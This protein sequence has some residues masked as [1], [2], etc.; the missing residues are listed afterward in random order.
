MTATTFG[1][2]S[3]V[4]VPVRR[5]EDPT[6]LRG[7]ATY[8][9]NLA[10]PGALHLAFVRSSYA[11]A[12]L[13]GVDT[14]D[15]R[16]MPGVVAVYTAGDL[17]FPDHT[18]MMQLNPNVV[19]PALARD[20]VRFVGD[21]IAV[22]VAETKAQAVD[23]A[24]TVV[25]EYEP[26]AAVTDM[27]DALAPDAPVQFDALG[28]NVIMGAR[29]PDGYDPLA[30]AEVVVRGRFENQRVAV[31]P[32]EGS[33]VAVVPGDDGDGHELT[34]YL[35]C[36]MPH[37]NRNALATNFGVE[38]EKVRLI[39]PHVGGSFGA[40][41]WAPEDIVAVRVARE[42][43]R[44]VKWVET[45]SENMIAMPHGRGQ[46][47]YLELGLLR[48]GT[49]VGLRCRI[50]GD[51]GAYGGFGGMLAFG[52]TRMMSQGVYRIPKI[53]YDCAVALTNLAPMGAYRG[54][55]RPEAAAMLERILDMAADELDIDPVD[56]RRRNFLQPD[57]FPYS[58]VTGVT[59]DIGDYDA[60]LT[61]A[62]RI[63]GYDELRAEQATRRERGDV[64]LLGIGV[65]AY[66]EIT[67]GGSSSEYAEV[68]VHPD[69]SATVKAGTSAH[70]QGHA[71][72]Y[73]QLVS[74]QLGIPIERISFVQSDTALV[75]RGGG[76]GGSRS[77]QIGGSAALE[78]S[79]GVL[80]RARSIA[81]ELLE[82][83][84]EDIVLT[85]D[86]MLGVAGVPSKAITWAEV[87]TKASDDGVP[88]VVEHDFVQ[89]GASFPFGVHV[90]VVE[91]DTETGR[92]VPLRHVAVDDCGRI[93]NPMLV[94]GQVHGG[95]ASGIAQALWEHM[96]YDEDGNP[97]TS[98]LAE[99]GIPSA[100]EFPTFEVA[101]TE[102][103]S[104]L[105]PLGAKG[106]GE[107]ATVGSTPAVQNAVV[108]ALSH[109]GVRHIDLPCTPERVWRAVEDARAGTLPDPWRE[110]PAAFATLRVR[111][112]AAP[113]RRAEEEIDL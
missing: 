50:I 106:I 68:E 74:G 86:G 41:H 23:A 107:S 12:E 80:E 81:A 91:V 110:P 58:T 15:A 92:V 9:D 100:A 59:Y 52:P 49:I 84:R 61:E 32:M 5:V 42:L 112:R 65:C 39:A 95:V 71:T 108:D 109:L 99:Y 38:P 55:G 16:A 90:S 24:E 26:L 78:A 30:G 94:D 19:R 66:V 62:L 75:P 82:A 33:A 96:V 13:T 69:G 20:R 40:K 77:L 60:A 67:A 57:E 2:G 51:S 8:I 85:D 104:P 56:I 21:A 97:L 98:T 25:V 76:T 73:S 37:S 70:G 4:G 36:Q 102:T 10:L 47:Q 44:P 43:G 113:S 103:P 1:A 87:S 34:V 89:S 79:R 28:S 31:V 53:G 54:A 27:E 111:E 3:L 83:A 105:N 6:L 93:L 22:V 63:A 7:E 64:R 17:E 45:R 88:L 46:V 18:G 101:H 14:A 72:A 35:A 11:H 29:E 48:D